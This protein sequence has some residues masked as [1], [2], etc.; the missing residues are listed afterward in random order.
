MRVSSHACVLNKVYLTSNLVSTSFVKLYSF[1]MFTVSGRKMSK[2]SH[3]SIQSDH[4]SHLR[5]ISSSNLCNILVRVTQSDASL[6]AVVPVVSHT[7]PAKFISALRA[8]H[9]HASWIFLNVCFAL[10]T[11]LSVDFFPE[12][13][14]VRGALIL[15]DFLNEDSS[16]IAIK[17]NMSLILTFKTISMATVTKHIHCNLIRLMNAEVTAWRRAPFKW[18]VKINKVLNQVLVIL[19]LVYLSLKEVVEDTPGDNIFAFVFRT[20]RGDAV[21]TTIHGTFDVHTK[22]RF[23]ESVLTVHCVSVAHRV[24]HEANLA[25]IFSVGSWR[26]SRH[27]F[28]LLCEAFKHSVLVP[29][30]FATLL[31]RL[32]AV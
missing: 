16:I 25:E 17:W 28:I 21:R 2:S 13:S 5:F 18:F 11:R 27:L 23:A 10:G 6:F 24:L 20:C 9:V 12:L 29:S 19:V 32:T 3:L 31:W 8:S 15:L 30:M 1:E 14:W 7:Q 26:R 22:A 4:L